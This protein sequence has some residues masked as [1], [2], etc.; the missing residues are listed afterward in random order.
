MACA[1]LVKVV[2][3]NNFVGVVAEKPWQAMQAAAKLTVTW[4]PGPRLAP[5]RDAYQQIRKEPSADTLLVDSGDVDETL[6]SA[7]TVLRATYLHPY[8]MHGSIGSSCAVADV[9]AD[10][11]TLWSATQS[12]YPDS[13]T[14]P[15]PSS[16]CKPDAVRVIYTRGA[17]CYGI[18]GADTV[19]YD[20]AVLS[21][22][23]GKPVR[24]QLSRKD[25]MAWEN[26]GNLFAIDQRVGSRR[27]RHDR[28]RGTTRP[29]PPPRAAGRATTR[30]ATSSPERCSASTR[31]RS[32][33]A[34]RRPRRRRR[35]TTDSNT[36]PSYIA[37][38]VRDSQNGAGV[39]RSERVLSHRVRS[40][41]FTGPLRAPER[42]QNTFA[43]ECFMDEV[44]AHVKADPVAYRLRHLSHARLS[45]A[46]RTA[47]KAANWQAR[48][49][50][51]PAVGATG[52]VSGRG[53]ACVCYEGDNGYVA[54]VAEVDVESGHRAACT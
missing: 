14:R 53:I 39:V 16:A 19:S 51:R 30:Q 34:R 13:R 36:A 15:R 23:V 7:A 28:R 48:P 41:F 47:A 6:A 40:P 5:Q 10:K 27:K 31:R 9:Q 50:P 12:V 22:A 17:G 45:E 46:V 49:S 35:S 2:V 3:K 44:A 29:G 42:L 8:Q 38:R 43:H 18:N 54:M 1:G 52:V 26:Y 32:T 33:R 20:A 11:A 21:Q 4:T 37:G 24:V 25:E